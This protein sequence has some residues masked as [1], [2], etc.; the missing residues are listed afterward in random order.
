LKKILSFII[1]KAFWVN[2]TIMLLLTLGGVYG[3]TIFLDSYTKHDEFIEV[4]DFEGFHYS[5][6]NDYIADKGLRFEI[7]DS[8]FNPNK[9]GGIVLEQIPR[10]GEQVKPNRKIYLTI[11]S[12]TP[13]SVILPEL[14]DITV[15][16]VVSKIETYGLKIDSLIYKPAECD[17]CVIGVLFEGKEVDSGTRIEK[18]KSISLI[19]GEGIGMEKVNVP[20]LYK[21]SL[22]EV[23]ELLNAQGLN[24]GFYEYDSTIVNVDDSANA[25][26]YKQIPGYD[27]LS[28]VRQGRAFDLFLTLDSNK[29]EG[30]ELMVSD[31][32]LIQNETN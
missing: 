13:P 20:Y 11:N 23:R 28:K 15:R 30:I 18:G 19:I 12:V 29:V 17:N 22:N 24:V 8:I 25:F 27:T 14:H 16:Q 6:V 5:E 32:N 31:T 9:E 2:I 7:V 21:L 3:V 26:V 10:K 4:P 1:S